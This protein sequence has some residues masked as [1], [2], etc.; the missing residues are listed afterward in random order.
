MGQRNGARQIASADCVVRGGTGINENGQVSGNLAV[1]CPETFDTHA[2]RWD[3]AIHD[4]GFLPG[5]FHFDRPGSESS[6]INNNAMVVGWSDIADSTWRAFLWDGSTMRNLG[7]LGGHLSKATA[8]ND[9]VQIAGWSFL[10]NDTDS[11]AFIWDSANGMHDIGILPGG[12]YSSA[13]G[14]NKG[15][16]VVG[17]GNIPPFDQDTHAFLWD[18]TSG[19]RDL[20]DLIP[21]DSGW[22]LIEATAINDS[23]QIVGWGYHDGQQ[24]AFLLSLPPREPLIFIPGIA[25]SRLNEVGGNNIWPAL[26]RDVSRLTLD[27]QQQQTNI[28]VPDVIRSASFLLGTYTE[29]VYTPLLQ[30]LS[31][32]GYREYK[33]NN[34]PTRRTT[35]GCDLTQKHDDPADNP[36]L[37]VFA[38]DWRKS[39]A[40]NANLLKDYIGCAQMFYPNTKVNVLAHSMGGLLA[41][42]YIIDNPGTHEVN[43]LITIA[44]PWLGAPK[45]IH[46]LETGNFFNQFILDHLFAADMK[47]LVEFFPGAHETLPGR[48]Y[49]TLGGRPFGEATWDYDKN[50]R[51]DPTYDT[52]NKLA[53]ALDRQHPRSNPGTLDTQFHD[54]TG[55]DDWRGDQSGVQYYHI[56]GVQKL[57]RTIG[58]AI[59]ISE[60]ICDSPGVNCKSVNSTKFEKVYG[61]GTAPLLSTERI[62]NGLNL[63]ASGSIKIP[64]TSSKAAD[65]DSYEHTYLTQNPT[66]WAAI[67]TA[68][69]PANSQQAK[70][71]STKSRSNTLAHHKL[72]ARSSF[73]VDDQ[74]TQVEGDPG[75]YVHATGIDFINVSDA[76]GNANTPAEGITFS[77]HVPGVDYE[78]DEK[79]IEITTPADQSFTLTFRSSGQPVLLEI[80]KGVGN[81]E[82]SQAIRYLDLNLPAGVVAKLEI[83]PTGVEDLRYDGDAD[84]T[85]EAVVTPT[86]NAIGTAAL[87]TIAPDITFS[88]S[89]QGT[90][91]LVSITGTDFGTGVRTLRYSF[92]GLHFLGYTQP[93]LVDPAQ[94]P[95]VFAFGEDN[96]A[97]SIGYCFLFRAANSVQFHR[98]LLP[99]CQ[100]PGS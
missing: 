62:G 27:P 25:G 32:E 28:V 10:S 37:F 74:P 90:Q 33:V 91:R 9:Q 72:N 22:V 8:I 13:N 45:A 16:L 42:R 46:V 24:G 93:F 96:V 5:S 49:F 84:G 12:N 76:Y 34:D 57:P 2:F 81:S 88:E 15:G 75:Y 20:N 82:P 29:Q 50:G 78:V 18:S 48:S 41:R 66:V 4:L 47:K 21:S 100:P 17:K 35:A 31:D 23:G 65:D 60:T 14:I 67:R 55:Q 53:S 79:S 77:S 94:T 95:S 89:Q 52:Y 36:N 69:A 98:I 26:F 11:H 7:S 80:L 54:R 43:K 51:L 1:N 38:Y 86:A 30:E 44:T 87:D 40:D 83:T 70:V 63:N 59:A 19:M 99:D 61:D 6:A 64:F 39:N 73:T 97:K 3:G 56:Y 92:D 71:P 68:L 58:K 85:F